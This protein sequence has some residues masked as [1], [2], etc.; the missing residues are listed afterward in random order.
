MKD[1]SWTTDW[2]IFASSIRLVSGP[3]S[4]AIEKLCQPAY[5]F[6]SSFFF[7]SRRCSRESA[8]AGLEKLRQMHP[9]TGQ[10]RFE[11]Q[12]HGR[13]IKIT[14]YPPERP[15]TFLI[16]LS[17]LCRFL[18][19]FFLLF[20]SLLARPSRFSSNVK[21]SKMIVSVDLNQLLRA[22]NIISKRYFI[23]SFSSPVSKTGWEKDFTF[24]RYFF[25]QMF[26]GALR[27]LV[28]YIILLI[29]RAIRNYIDKK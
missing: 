28:I 4:R 14:G 13:R 6:F 1:S 26:R 16:L 5:I 12:I 2:R 18:L 21:M 17:L 19:F 22:R 11:I 8:I 20:F 15:N 7:S 25:V 27:W 23:I 3:R 10:M 24:Y 29:V 9:K